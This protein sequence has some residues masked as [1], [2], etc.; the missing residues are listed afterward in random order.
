MGNAERT[1]KNRSYALGINVKYNVSNVFY[2]YVY[3]F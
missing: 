3:F 1:Y 2:N